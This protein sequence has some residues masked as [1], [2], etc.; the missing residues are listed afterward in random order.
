MKR[1]KV[2][3]VPE[4][5]N[6][7]VEQASIPI[8]DALQRQ[9]RVNSENLDVMEQDASNSDEY[10]TLSCYERGSSAPTSS[11][12]SVSRLKSESSG[13]AIALEPTRVRCQELLTQILLKTFAHKN[14]RECN[15]AL[16]SD[17]ASAIEQSIARDFNGIVTPGYKRQMKTHLNC[18]R[19]NSAL[20]RRLLEGTVT[21]DEVAHMSSD[22][23]RTAGAVNRIRQVAALVE[24]NAQLPH[25]E[26]TI[27]GQ[28]LLCPQCKGDDVSMSA[29]EKKMKDVGTPVAEVTT[30]TPPL[31]HGVPPQ[32]KRSGDSPVLPLGTSQNA[33]EAG[34]MQASAVLGTASYIPALE[35]SAI[36]VP[37]DNTNAAVATTDLDAS[38]IVSSGTDHQRHDITNTDMQCNTC[39]HAWIDRPAAPMP[40]NYS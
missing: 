19:K 1:R 33:A 2:L 15:V 23:M 21:P 5:M 30:K 24:R 8:N 25:I 39:G 9:A 11:I 3:D 7:T 10:V 35:T 17:I 18:L 28:A 31:E 20:Q 27:G 4:P 16:A 37:A 34:G 29:A 40:C 26:P 32:A 22:S 14:D 36:V 6:R 13:E 38:V 12:E